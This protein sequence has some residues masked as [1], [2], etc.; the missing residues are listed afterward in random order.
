MTLEEDI[1][2]LQKYMVSPVEWTVSLKGELQIKFKL[3]QFWT[4][5]N[6]FSIYIFKTFAENIEVVE[7]I[8]SVCAIVTNFF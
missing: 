4:K 2:R 3:Q 6:A 1:T 8:L 7:Q 5:K